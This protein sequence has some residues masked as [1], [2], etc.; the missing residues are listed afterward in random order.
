M[1]KGYDHLGPAAL[2]ESFVDRVRVVWQARYTG[3]E[4][5][6]VLVRA[7]GLDLAA[8]QKL[9]ARRDDRPVFIHE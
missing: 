8:F 3:G 5:S 2:A 1:C 7:R 9:F 6:A 4:R